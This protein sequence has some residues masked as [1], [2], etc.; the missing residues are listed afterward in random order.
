[1]WFMPHTFYYYNGP[2]CRAGLIQRV[3]SLYFSRMHSKGSCFTLGVWGLSCVRPTLRLRPQ[4]FAAFSR[5]GRMAVRMGSS[6]KGVTFE[7]F[8]RRV[9]SFRMA[10]VAL[11]DIPTCFKTCQEQFYVAGAV[12]FRRFQRMMCSFR[13]SCMFFAVFAAEDGSIIMAFDIFFPTCQVFFLWFYVKCPAP[14][15]FLP[16][17]RVLLVLLLAR[18]H[19][20][21][22]DCSGPRRTSAASPWSQRS[23]PDLICQLLIAAGLA[24][25]P[26]PALDRSGP[27]RTAAAS[28]RSQWASP[29]LRCQI[30]C[31]KICQIECQKIFQ[32][33][34]QKI[35]QIECQIECQKICQ[36]ECQKIWQTECQIDVPDRMSNRMP[37]RTLEDLPD[38][39]SD[40][41][42][43]MPW[44]GSLEA[45]W[46][47]H[48]PNAGD[49]F[50]EI[51][52]YEMHTE[53]HRTQT[54]G[55]AT[56]IC[57][58]GCLTTKLLNYRTTWLP[59]Q[60]TN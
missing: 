38:R 23:S 17:F 57:E 35:F 59:N 43:W 32:I 39:M 50:G 40:G 56:S 9:A 46:Y 53:H 5:E 45:S 1:M 13:G 55:Q 29:D 37:D 26:L 49:S 10:G 48:N 16:S 22:L 3:V 51:P 52:G 11:C 47:P 42:N 58:F 25:P 27:R 20:P 33:E 36:I 4:P 18:P 19:L 30:E 14:P 28:S 7:A 44:W 15:S 12:L 6:A 41:M 34:C 21:A 54:C 24:G 2:K 8:Q 60:R 31:Q